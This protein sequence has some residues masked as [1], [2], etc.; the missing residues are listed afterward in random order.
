MKH[1]HETQHLN[2]Y[3]F[4][5]DACNRPFDK[6]SHKVRHKCNPGLTESF[7]YRSGQPMETCTTKLCDDAGTDKKKSKSGV[8]KIKESKS[9]VASKKSKLGVG[10]KKSTSGV[11][12]NKSK[13]GVGRPTKQS[14]SGVAK[15]KLKPG[16][17]VRSDTVTIDGSDTCDVA[18][19]QTEL[20]NY[21]N[22]NSAG[23]KYSG[24]PG[25][26]NDDLK[27]RLERHERGGTTVVIIHPPPTS[28]TSGRRSTNEEEL[29]SVETGDDVQPSRPPTDGNVEDRQRV[30]LSV[31]KT[32]GRI[33]VTYLPAATMTQQQLPH[34][35][36]Q[37][38][39]TTPSRATSA[40]SGNE[41]LLRDS[42]TSSE[43][44][45]VLLH[46]TPSGSQEIREDVQ[47]ALSV[48]TLVGSATIPKRN[49]AALGNENEATSAVIGSPSMSC[50]EAAVGINTEPTSERRSARQEQRR[51]FKALKLQDQ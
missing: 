3:R 32:P 28:Y 39:T 36:K 49:E 9:G 12:T 4:H 7:H 5:C 30:S 33:L 18:T 2:K 14:K 34:A 26:Q 11:A 17:D 45:S 27:D 22:E 50:I 41:V 46:D 6:L 16:S 31:N 1:H 13:T 42:P 35:V 48:D 44:I 29:H 19:T 23:V 51:M 21:V 38:D 24:L 43:V 8:V 10:T 25:D 37:S 15:D 47:S 40:V 20:Q